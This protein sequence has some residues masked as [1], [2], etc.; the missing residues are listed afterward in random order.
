RLHGRIPCDC[1]ALTDHI[2]CPLDDLFIHEAWRSLAPGLAQVTEHVQLRTIHVPVEDT[3]D[4]KPVR[5]IYLA[6]DVI[7]VRRH[8]KRPINDAGIESD[9]GR[10]IACAR[11]RRKA[12]EVR[13]LRRTIHSVG[14]VTAVEPPARNLVAP[15]ERPVTDHLLPPGAELTVRKWA[16]LP[17]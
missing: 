17:F 14:P 5:M 3:P 15:A 1:S 2:A 16:V 9:D 7:L 10:W 13:R 4:R 12:L 11:R 6:R 8:G